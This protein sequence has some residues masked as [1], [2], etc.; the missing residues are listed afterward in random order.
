MRA[1]L[2]LR[3]QFAK[4]NSFGKAPVH[5]ARPWPYNGPLDFSLPRSG[6]DDAEKQPGRSESGENQN[7]GNITPDENGEETSVEDEEI[8]EGSAEDANDTLTEQFALDE[9]PERPFILPGFRKSGR[10]I[11]REFQSWTDFV[12]CTGDESLQAWSQY[13]IERRSHKP[14]NPEKPFYSTPN[15]ETAIDMALRTG[16]PEGRKLL[17]DS[18]V[19]VIPRPSIF[20]S[21]IYEVAGPI[22]VVPIYITGDP[23]CMQD[24]Q[25]DRL[26]VNKIVRIDYSRSAGRGIKPET[27]MN[28]GAAVLSLANSLEQQGYSTELRIVNYVT[29][30]ETDFFSAIVYKRAGEFLDIDRAAF[31]LAHPSMHRRLV[32]ALREQHKE[33]EGEYAGGMGSPNQNQFEETLAENTIFIPGAD[34]NETLE[35]SRRAVEQ[36]AQ[37]YLQKE[38]L[39]V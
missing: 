35:E 19:A 14:D 28:R 27:T 37:S 18:L 6:G 10:T 29:E 20:A 17:Y 4:P 23:A 16:W 3:R 30:W 7:P 31:A 33:I 2:K 25:S 1:Q 32:W 9:P 11:I 21:E 8:E 39:V 12:L 5:L 26:A 15:F 34:R 13:N 38:D 22:P 36:A 24:W